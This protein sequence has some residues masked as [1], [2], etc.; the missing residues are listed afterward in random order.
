MTPQEEKE[1]LLRVVTKLAGRQIEK[2]GFIPFG[3]TLGSKR[4]VRLLMPESMKKEVTRDELDAYWTREIRKAIIGGECKT[5]C[6][7]ADV[8]LQSEEGTLF[9][10][11][12]VHVEHVGVFSE[13]ILFPYKKE[14]NSAVVF[15]EPTTE[16]MQ[17]Q[18]FAAS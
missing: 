9:P 8:R 4:D 7:I 11:I 1:L 12:M 16:A 3:A 17:H 2:G 5:A 14:E 13:D 18:I 6:W 15:G 10:A